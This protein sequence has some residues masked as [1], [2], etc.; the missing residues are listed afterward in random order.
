MHVILSGT[1]IEVPVITHEYVHMG[2]AVRNSVLGA[3]DE[4]SFKPVSSATETS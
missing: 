2:L 3:S 1:A 4:M